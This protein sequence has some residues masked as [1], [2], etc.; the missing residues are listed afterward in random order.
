M[1]HLIVIYEDRPDT[2]FS[3]MYGNKELAGVVGAGLLREGYE[4]ETIAQIITVEGEEV[5]SFSDP[6]DIEKWGLDNGSDSR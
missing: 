4:D 1:I 3:K 6:A 5:N 2:S